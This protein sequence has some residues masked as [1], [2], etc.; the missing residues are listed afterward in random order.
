MAHVPWQLLRAEVC[1]VRCPLIDLRTQ[2][3]IY[4]PESAGIS[5]GVNLARIAMSVVSRSVQ[6]PSP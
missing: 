6:E 3:C 4:W 2:V 5:G 1:G